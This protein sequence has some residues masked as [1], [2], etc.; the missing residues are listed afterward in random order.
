M[1]V[2]CVNSKY[3]NQLTYGKI[4]EIIVS[5][6]DE[7]GYLTYVIKCDDGEVEDLPPCLF[8]SIDDW[9]DLRIKNIMS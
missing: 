8:I 5:Y 9:R 3:N 7:H 1:K 6:K 4:Y 2:V